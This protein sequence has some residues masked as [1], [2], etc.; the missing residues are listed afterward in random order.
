MFSR[1]AGLANKI[2]NKEPGKY[3]HWMDYAEQSGYEKDFITD[4]KGVLNV[5]ALTIPVPLYWALYMQN[6]SIPTG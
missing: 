2:K 4:S 6:V 1:K 5:L 3:E